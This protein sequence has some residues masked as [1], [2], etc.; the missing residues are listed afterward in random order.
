MATRLNWIRHQEP[1]KEEFMMK[2][3]GY[4]YIHSKGI[5]RERKHL[6]TKNGKPPVPGKS[7]TAGL[8]DLIP[9]KSLVSNGPGIWDR[10]MIIVKGNNVEHWLNNQMTVEYERGTDNWKDMVSKSK[11]K[12]WPKFGEANEGHILLQDHGGRVSFRNIKIR[13]IKD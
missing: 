6:K 4:G 3:E 10:A 5:Q 11:F 8:Y 12:T 7:T 2:H 13:E 9:P 1:G